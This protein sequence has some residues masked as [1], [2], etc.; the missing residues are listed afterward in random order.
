MTISR[1]F[2]VI[3]LLSALSL[4]AHADADALNDHLGPREI[5]TGEASRAE[6]RGSLA[7]SLNPAGLPLTRELVFE[8]GYGY[9]H[10]DNA[11]T[12]AVS[13]CDSTVPMPGCFYYRYFRATPDINNMDFGRRSHEAGVALARS[14]TPRVSLGITNRYFD[15]NSDLTGEDDSS[16]WGSD[17]GILV[18]ATDFV[19]VGVVGYNL[20]SADS[21]QYPRAIGGGISARPTGQL[22]LAFDSLWNLEAPDGQSTGRYGGG[23][24]YFFQSADMQNGYPIRLGGLYDAGQESGYITGGVGYMHAKF[25]FDLGVR[26]Q[27]SGTQMDGS[28]E[29]MV[30][31]SIR[32]FGPRLA[33]GVPEQPVF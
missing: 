15:Y 9:R 21:A 3:T 17:A 26:K 13:A 11:S 23:A 22:M 1:A 29:L 33:D 12:V 27:L 16:G 2:A 20:L 6:A 28:S 10:A 32:L 19:N 7:V 31:G 8:G 25:G 30:L 5:S 4:D 14:L 18:R 24:E